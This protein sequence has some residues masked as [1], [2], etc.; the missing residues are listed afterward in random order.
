MAILQF[1]VAMAKKMPAGK[2]RINYHR[3]G[4]IWAKGQML[5]G[6]MNG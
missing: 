1:E 6:Q 2:E 4:S 5:V 3:D